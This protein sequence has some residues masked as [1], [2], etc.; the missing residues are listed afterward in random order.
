MT[1]SLDELSKQHE[2][3]L[4]AFSEKALSTLGRIAVG[5][6]FLYMGST[7]SISALFV[8]ENWN[9]LKNLEHLYVVGEL[10]S[11]LEE[12]FTSLLAADDPQ[13]TVHIKNIVWELSDYRRCSLYFSTIQGREFLQVII[14]LLH[15]V[16]YLLRLHIHV[17]LL[18]SNNNNNNNSIIKFISHF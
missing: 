11:M 6:A 5:V 18:N 15:L 3:S 8:C 12:R 16:N 1:I 13:V 9:G 17:F 7:N 14:L 10:Q 2:S 4:I